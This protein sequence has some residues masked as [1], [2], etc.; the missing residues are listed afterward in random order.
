MTTKSK[1][2]IVLVLLS[3]IGGLLSL[4]VSYMNLPFLIILFLQ[5]FSLFG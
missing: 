2:G 4:I 3:I 1:I 5:S